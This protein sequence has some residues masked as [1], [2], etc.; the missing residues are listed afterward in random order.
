V[1]V[2]GLGRP[3]R[4][5]GGRYASINTPVPERKCNLNPADLSA[6]QHT[7]WS[8][9]LRR[10]LPR[11]NVA[12]EASAGQAKLDRA[13]AAAVTAAGVHAPATL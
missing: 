10:H 1:I 2:R 4:S 11:T 13:L 7:L 3:G 8:T 9:G 5:N 6:A 12:L